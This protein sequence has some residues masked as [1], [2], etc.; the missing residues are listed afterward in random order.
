MSRT[1]GFL[2]KFNQY[3]KIKLK[4]EWIRTLMRCFIWKLMAFYLYFVPTKWYKILTLGVQY[5]TNQLIVV[6]L[7]LL[8]KCDY[9]E[10]AFLLV[11]LLFWLLK[12]LIVLV[13]DIVGRHQGDL[14]FLPLIKHKEMVCYLT[15]TSSCQINMGYSNKKTAININLLWA[16][17][18]NP[19][20][21]IGE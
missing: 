7:L 4:N 1:L 10:H 6:E 13:L 20:L 15:N 18:V 5:S 16:S 8:N 21:R 3:K 14:L 17:W 9:L 19:I 12:V 11:Q 2:D